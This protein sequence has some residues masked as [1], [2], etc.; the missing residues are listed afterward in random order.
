MGAQSGSPTPIAATESGS[1]CVRMPDAHSSEKAGANESNAPPKF[2]K[3]S[4]AM[5]KTSDKTVPPQE[6]AQ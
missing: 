3:K 6:L 2:F 5:P 1:L 4:L